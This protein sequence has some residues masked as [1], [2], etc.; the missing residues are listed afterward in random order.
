MFSKTDL[1]GVNMC[2]VM[3]RDASSWKPCWGPSGMAGECWDDSAH[4]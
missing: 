3:Q 2:V 4:G 1:K